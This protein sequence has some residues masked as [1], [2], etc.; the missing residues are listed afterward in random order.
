MV[1]DDVNAV[2]GNLDEFLGPTWDLDAELDRQTRENGGRATATATAAG[3]G[4]GMS[5][6]SGLSQSGLSLGF[7]DSGVWD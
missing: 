7:V 1:V 4:M 3:G 5:S 2:M 6:F